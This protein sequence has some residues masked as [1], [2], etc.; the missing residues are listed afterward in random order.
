MAGSV[1]RQAYRASS[2]VDCLNSVARMQQS[3]HRRMTPRL[4]ALKRLY[5]NS[6]EFGTG[7][8]RKQT[9]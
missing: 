1:L 8:R 4:L 3:R 6:R 9:P 7:R 5:W 2:L